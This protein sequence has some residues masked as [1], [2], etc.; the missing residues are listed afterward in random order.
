[1]VTGASRGHTIDP[2]RSRED[3]HEARYICSDWPAPCAAAMFATSGYS[4]QPK[5]RL[6]MASTFPGSFVLIG[7][8]AT[9]P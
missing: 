3:K 7:E 6:N 8:S 9:K 4:Q 5:L 1:M 2:R